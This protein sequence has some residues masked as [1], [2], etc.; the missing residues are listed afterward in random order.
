MWHAR[1]LWHVSHFCID[2][3]THCMNSVYKREDKKAS[4]LCS[5]QVTIAKIMPVSHR[6]LLSY[7]RSGVYFALTNVP[8]LPRLLVKLLLR[9]DCRV[10][11]DNVI[12]PSY[13]LMKMYE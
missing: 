12:K 6:L 2:V 9:V 13:G 8:W 1:L 4:D 5:N 3:S 11:S 10:D 7:L